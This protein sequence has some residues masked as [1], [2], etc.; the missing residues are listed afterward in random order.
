MFSIHRYFCPAC[1]KGFGVG[2]ADRRSEGRVIWADYCPSCDVKLQV[3]GPPLILLGAFFGILPA[4]LLCCNPLVLPFA[5]IYIAVGV[6]RV[7][8]QSRTQRRNREVKA[9]GT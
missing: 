9:T 4:F 7:V 5:C 3:S 2:E 8:R 6:M 1:G